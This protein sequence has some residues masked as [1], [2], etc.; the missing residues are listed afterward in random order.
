MGSRNIDH[1]FFPLYFLFCIL[2]IFSS[3]SAE[4]EQ[5]LALLC[6]II[7]FLTGFIHPADLYQIIPEDEILDDIMVR[8]VAGNINVYLHS[9]KSLIKKF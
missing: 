8:N 4:Q 2:K 7:P 1:C 5:W 9:W 3:Q 6:K